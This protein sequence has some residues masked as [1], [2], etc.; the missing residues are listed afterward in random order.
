MQQP[1]C[2][3]PA[4]RDPYYWAHLKEKRRWYTPSSQCYPSMREPKISFLLY[5][6][7]PGVLVGG[8]KEEEDKPTSIVLAH[9]MRPHGDS[10]SRTSAS[11]V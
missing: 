7:S 1:E 5:L 4:D 10:S 9:P 3:C 2:L 8:W 6:H 11:S